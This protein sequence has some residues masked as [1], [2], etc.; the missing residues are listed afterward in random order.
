MQVDFK[1]FILIGPQNVC[2]CMQKYTLA[3][4]RVT[5]NVCKLY[6][7]NLRGKIVWSGKYQILII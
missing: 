5:Q 6:A 1:R 4:S 3:F 2:K 7:N